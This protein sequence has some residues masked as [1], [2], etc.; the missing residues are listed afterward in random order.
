MNVQYDYQQHLMSLKHYFNHEHWLVGLMTNTRLRTVEMEGKPKL[1][2]SDQRSYLWLLTLLSWTIATEAFHL[3]DRLVFFSAFKAPSRNICSHQVFQLQVR[4]WEGKV[5]LL[6]SPIVVHSE[7]T[8]LFKNN[9]KAIYLS[10]S[11][12]SVVQDVSLNP[13][14]SEVLHGRRFKSSSDT[15]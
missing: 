12:P 11:S 10:Y 2:C 7:L 14:K 3:M 15:R 9:T 13:P 1:I 5:L 8:D 6:I 4:Q